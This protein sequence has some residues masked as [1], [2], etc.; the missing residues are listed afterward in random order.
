VK[1]EPEDGSHDGNVGRF[2]CSRALD[3]ATL[4]MEQRRGRLHG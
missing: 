4:E 2:G 3:V 1:E